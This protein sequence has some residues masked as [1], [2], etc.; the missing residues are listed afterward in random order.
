MPASVAPTHV[1]TL[2]AEVLVTSPDYDVE[3]PELGGALRRA[4]LTPRLAPKL[5]ARSAADMRALVADAAAAIVS[6]DPF[7]AAVLAAAPRLRVIAR[8]GVG[9]DS[10]DLDA[11]TAH[12]VAV[13]T[14]PGANEETVADHALAMMLGVLRRLAEHDAGVRRPRAQAAPMPTLAPVVR[15]REDTWRSNH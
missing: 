10:I 6:T 2:P 12:G 1:P 8:V 14:T 15:A 4:G 9:L 3:H 7:D 11:A 13:T 5:G